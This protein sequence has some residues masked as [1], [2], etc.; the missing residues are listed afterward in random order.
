MKPS[1]FKIFA[2]LALI[3]I[4]TKF[5]GVIGGAMANVI[6][7]FEGLRLVAYQD[8]AGIW[9]IGY[10]LTRYPNGQPVRQG[11]EIT[12]L[13]AEQYFMET[14][15][16]FSQGVEDLI[17][18]ELTTNQFAALVS[19]AY[20]IGLTAFRNSTILDMVNQNPNDPDIRAQFM[21]WV[22]AGGVVNQGLINR[23]TQE[24]NLYFS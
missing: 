7:Q 3:F 21:R 20:N 15:T 24:A 12:P 16:T 23:R 2:V 10:G 19:L 8:S 9:T 6:K 14:L 4:I 18:V 17:N 22:Y 13:Q 5:K 11:D 1:T